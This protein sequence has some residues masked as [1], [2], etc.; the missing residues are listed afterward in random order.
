MNLNT[1]ST[2]LLAVHIVVVVVVLS[3]AVILR[4]R[5]SGDLGSDLYVQ[6]DPHRFRG[7]LQSP[8]Q[9][10]T[11]EHCGEYQHEHPRQRHHRKHLQ[12]WPCHAGKCVTD[13]LRWVHVPKPGL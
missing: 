8:V 4:H 7:R 12:H 1:I 11:K 13:A 6:Q 9:P 10:G 2:Q 3:R 5:S